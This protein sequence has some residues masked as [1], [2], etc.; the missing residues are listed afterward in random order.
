M[1][2]KPLS[3]RLV[4]EPIEQDA[5]T[6]SGIFLLESAREKPMRGKVLAVG[7]GASKK[8]DGSRITM[9]VS[10]GNIVL[11]A[12]HAGIRIRFEDKKYVILQ[13]TDVLAIVH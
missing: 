10:T 13:E 11:F 5:L 6:A 1:N 4:V 2:L 8:E 3:D 12:N 9:D 7:P